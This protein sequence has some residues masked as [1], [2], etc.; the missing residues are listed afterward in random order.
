[1]KEIN[2]NIFQCSSDVLVPNQGVNTDELLN[3]NLDLDNINGQEAPDEVEKM[4]LSDTTVNEVSVL[5]FSMWPM[6]VVV[7][8]R[9]FICGCGRCFIFNFSYLLDFLVGLYIPPH[10]ITV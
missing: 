6:F 5:T 9:C 4:I 2:Q 1:M 10:N 8:G 3:S 7:C